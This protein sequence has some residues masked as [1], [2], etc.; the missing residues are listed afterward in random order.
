V[1]INQGHIYQFL[2]KPWEPE[3]LLAAV[4]QAAVEYDGIETIALEREHL[5]HEV[6]EL[7]E[8]VAAL[9]AEVRRLHTAFQHQPHLSAPAGRDDVST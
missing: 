5:L 9:E 8:R 6:T 4:R 7:K 1:A 2:K 3:E